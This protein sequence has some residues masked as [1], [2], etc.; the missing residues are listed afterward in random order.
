MFVKY[1]L[2]ARTWQIIEGLA[3]APSPSQIVGHRVGNIGKLDGSDE[4]GGGRARLAQFNC[5]N[6]LLNRPSIQYPQA[7]Y[8]IQLNS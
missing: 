5:S 2:A 1:H 3:T 4:R 8:P 7:S 6:D